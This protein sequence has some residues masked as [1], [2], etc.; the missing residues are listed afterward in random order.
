LAMND[1]DVT[2]SVPKLFF[3]YATGSNLL[4]PFAFGGAA[5]LFPDKPTPQ[6]LFELS[7]AHG[8]TILIS[9]PTM[10]AQ[11]AEHYERAAEKP[12]LGALRV[13]TSAGEAL[14][15]ELYQRWKAKI[16]V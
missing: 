15:P 4:F 3:G 11:M 5:I 14:P 16:G 2:L 12:N 9:V 6:R 13:V 1:R 8:A 10:I 7:A